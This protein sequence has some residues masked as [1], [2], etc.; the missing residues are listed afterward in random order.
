MDAGL[1]SFWFPVYRYRGNIFLVLNG[2]MVSTP[3]GSQWAEALTALL[4]LKEYRVNTL[5]VL[6]GYRVNTLLVSQ[7]VQG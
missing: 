5:L 7:C 6:N 3:S 4:V 2:H 1:S